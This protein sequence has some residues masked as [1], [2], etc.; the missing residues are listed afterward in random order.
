[1]EVILIVLA[2]VVVFLLGNFLVYKMVVVSALRKFIKPYIQERGWHFVKYRFVGL[3]N[4]GDFEKKRF[5]I[6]PVPRMGNIVN[7][8]YI[9]VYATKSENTRFRFTAKITSFFLL[10]RKVEYKAP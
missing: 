9:Y 5:V 6:R 7:N 4:C 8:A 10:V 1:M 3:L 2:A